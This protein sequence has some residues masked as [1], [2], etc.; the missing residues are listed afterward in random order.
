MMPGRSDQLLHNFLL[1]YFLI[2]KKCDG[3][4]EW[5][6]AGGVQPGFGSTS[7]PVQDAIPSP[8]VSASRKKQKTSHSVPS[9]SAG[10]PSPALH[11]QAIAPSMQPS[12]SVVKRGAPVVAKAK[13]PKS[14]SMRFS[15]KFLSNDS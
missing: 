7:Q 3:N 9:I 1:F 4:R 14:V 11:Q 8:T 12:S 2:G 15:N 6:Q 5:R 13:K 10:A